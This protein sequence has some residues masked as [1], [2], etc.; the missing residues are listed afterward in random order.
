MSGWIFKDLGS[1]PYP[2]NDEARVVHGVSVLLQ[3]V[4]L[5][6]AEKLAS[7]NPLG[8]ALFRV[9]SK[10]PVTFL[11]FNTSYLIVTTSCTRDRYLNHIGQDDLGPSIDELRLRRLITTSWSVSYCKHDGVFSHSLPRPRPKSNQKPES[12]QSM[13]VSF[14]LPCF[15]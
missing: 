11:M 6:N 7:P 13:T 4:P 1:Y 10:P 2:I 15:S 9:R 8:E 14:V 3:N 5:G 12:P